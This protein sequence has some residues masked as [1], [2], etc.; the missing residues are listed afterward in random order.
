MGSTKFVIVTAVYNCSKYIKRC[1]DS[2]ASQRYD[3]YEQIIIDDASTD[4]TYTVSFSL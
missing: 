1:I 3:N 4:D 2:V